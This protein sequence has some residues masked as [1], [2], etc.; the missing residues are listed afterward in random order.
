MDILSNS[1]TRT[2]VVLGVAAALGCAT[3]GAPTGHAAGSAAAGR[4][5]A[6]SRPPEGSTPVDLDGD[7]KPDAWTLPGT[8]G[9]PDVIAYDLDGDGAPDVLLSFLGGRLVRSELLHD[10]GSVPAT[11]TGFADGRLASKARAH[12][13]GG[14]A[15]APERWRDGV[16]DAG[17]DASGGASAAPGD[18]RP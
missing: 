18:H 7:G 14:G 15:I 3:G 9:A 5:Q 2:V 17:A 16:P 12:D 10:M 11:S 13:G 4:K 1:V 8:G 6:I